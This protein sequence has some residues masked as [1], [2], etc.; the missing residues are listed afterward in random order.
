MKRFSRC[1]LICT[2]VFLML[3][4]SASATSI[5]DLLPNEPSSTNDS[6]APSYGNICGEEPVS[7]TPNAQNDT[8]VTYEN[9]SVEDVDRFGTYLD[10][11]DYTVTEKQVQGNQYGYRISNGNITFSMVYDNS[12]HTMNLI[13]PEGIE[14]E[15]I[16]FPGYKRLLL[17]ETVRIEGLGEFT[18]NS[19]SMPEKIT[20][21][22][23][24]SYHG[25]GIYTDDKYSFRG[26]ILTFSYYNSTS[27][28][29]YYN[30]FERRFTVDKNNSLFDE[31]LQYL[32]D[33]IKYPAVSDNMGI[34]W[35]NNTIYSH[36]AKCASAKTTNLCMAYKLE[37]RISSS[38][39]GTIGIAFAFHGGGGRTIMD[40][41]KYVL[42]L[43]ENG[44]NL[45]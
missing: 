24:R 1:L 23:G 12:N 20:N 3:S 38:T 29:R 21:V 33:G 26:A 7:T 22:Y 25:D 35:G 4:S 8:I 45:Y 18:F 43:R 40:R 15:P 13:Y 37:N 10:Q 32:T 27:D 14:Y 36:L 28:A 42:V 31:E 11:R 30:S 41:P 9:V 16:M 2:L 19:F 5:F 44:N 6:A 34:D 17:G 39:D